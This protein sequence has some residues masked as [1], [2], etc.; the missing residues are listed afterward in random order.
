MKLNRRELHDKTCPLKKQTLPSGVV[1]HRVCFLTVLEAHCTKW[2][3]NNPSK[4][5]LRSHIVSSDTQ[6]QEMNYETENQD[7][8]H[9]Y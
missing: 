1:K 8:Q 9:T 6:S 7:D 4:A 5:G 3:S 2:N